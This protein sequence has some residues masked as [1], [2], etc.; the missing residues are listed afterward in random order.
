MTTPDLVPQPLPVLRLNQGDPSEARVYYCAHFVAD[1]LG[2][3]ADEGVAVS[4]TTTE[5]GGAT[6]RGGQVPAVI[7]GSADLTIGGPMVTMKI[8]EERGPRLVSFCAAVAAN[9][10][11]LAARAPEP[12]FRLS[13]L[14][15][16]R[17]LDIANIGTATL[18]FRWLAAR[19]GLAEADMA[20]IPGSG[21]HEADLDAVASG[22]VDYALHSLHALG[23]AI[24]EGRLALVQDLAGPTGAVPWSAYIAR[25]EAIAARRPAFLAFTRAIA[26]A[27]AWIGSHEGAEIAAIIAPRYPFQSRA[28]L[29]TI[30]AGYRKAGAFAAGPLIPR[31]DFDHF[32]AILAAIG[33]IG[34]PPPY[35]ELVEA[36]LARE[37]VRS[38]PDAVSDADP[39]RT[40]SW[41]R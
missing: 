4:F 38:R 7:D 8:H 28:A 15:G 31:A 17:V 1:A 20:L 21:S 18:C 2:L 27:L 34:A 10:W 9:P 35:A 25:P 22:A 26:R 16:R 19:A 3:F 41:T 12:G 14:R 36:G 33:W 29:E 5:S 30:I 39:E 13:D 11:V 40:P 24:A 37:A 23:P 32:A 6:V